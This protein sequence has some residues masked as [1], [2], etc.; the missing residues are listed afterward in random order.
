MAI[1]LGLIALSLQVDNVN[2]LSTKELFC[3][4][5]ECI[6][7]LDTSKAPEQLLQEFNKAEAKFSQN[8]FIKVN[9]VGKNW[10]IEDKDNKKTY[11]AR[12]KGNEIQILEKIKIFRMAPLYFLINMRNKSWIVMVIYLYS[13][14]AAFLSIL[15]SQRGIGK[16]LF[17]IALENYRDDLDKEEMPTTLWN[18]I[19]SA[20]KSDSNADEISI[21]VDE[22]RSSWFIK[23]RKKI[24]IVKKD[25][26]TIGIY[27]YKKTNIMEA[28]FYYISILASGWPTFY[29]ALIVLYYSVR[30]WITIRLMPLP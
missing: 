26:D 29:L 21:I 22:A 13:V 10:Q 16:P 14:S 17:Q 15:C 20:I 19:K 28:I 7:D 12:L 18:R 27:P 2:S 1:C 4:G 8:A 24:Y 3:I 23:D 6:T 30:Y 11:E 5:L 25:D 9:K